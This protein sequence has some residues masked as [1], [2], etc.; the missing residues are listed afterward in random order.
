[1]TRMLTIMGSGETSPTMVRTHKQL[2]SALGTA[3]RAVML[4]TPFGFQSN[5]DELTARAQEYFGTSIGHALEVVGY[6]GAGPRGIAYDEAMER[7]RRSD[8]VFAGP[9]SPSYALRHWRR[10]LVPQILVEKLQNRGA[11]TFASAAALTLGAVTVPVYEIYKVGEEPRWLEGLD[12]LGDVLGLRTAVIPHFNNAEGGTHD[13]R[14]CYLGEERLEA[15]E[16]QLPPDVVVL[17]VDEH[18]G[19]VIDLE[20]EVASVVGIGA[21]TLRRQGSDTELRSGVSVPIGEFAADGSPTTSARA[22]AAAHRSAH[23]GGVRTLLQSIEELERRFGRG[24]ADCDVDLAVGALLESEALLA[25]GTA[26]APEPAEAQRS[27]DLLRAMILRLGEAARGS[28]DEA[29]VIRPFLQML[30]D[31]RASARAQG[32]WAD[33]DAIR[34]GLASLGVE[35]RDAEDGTTWALHS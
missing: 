24:I 26:D 17:G 29:A 35:V 19:L 4:D 11:V 15:L 23:E 28:R 20:R 32:R 13:T 33:A 14:F 9:G 30:L 1:M 34:D 21:V 27:R 10:S 7:L 22:R 16:A 8:Y 25:D 5:A 12:V 2:L 18:T 31:L 6:R 3:P